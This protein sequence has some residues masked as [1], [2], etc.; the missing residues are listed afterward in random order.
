MSKEIKKYNKRG[1]LI[2]CKNS[3]NDEI[4]CEYDENNNI[5]HYK[6]SRDWEYWKKYDE[7]NNCIYYKDTD[8]KEHWYK[9]DNKNNPTRITKQKFENIRIKEYNSRT[10]C[11]RFE[12]ME[13]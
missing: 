2:Y 8:G 13:I 1:N 4:W 9:Y 6:N 11:S 3:F 10:K 12:I 7:N 5:I